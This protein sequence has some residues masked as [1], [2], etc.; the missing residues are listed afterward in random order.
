MAENILELGMIEHG[1][2]HPEGV[3][4]GLDG[5]VYAGG[6]AGQVYRVD[7]ENK[8]YGGIRQYRWLRAGA[9]A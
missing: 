4:V 5:K 3:A 7:L 6:E 9:G 1:M 2:D 8:H